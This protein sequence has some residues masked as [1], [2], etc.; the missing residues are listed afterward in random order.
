[1]KTRRTVLVLA[2]TNCGKLRE[3]RRA[4]KGLPVRIVTLAEV[5]IR[6]V[7]PERGRTFSENARGKSLYYSRRPG[8]LTLAEDSGLVVDALAGAPGI[9]SARFSAPRATAAKNNRKVLRLLKS[10][11]AGKRNARFVCSMALANNG[12]LLRTVSGVVRGTIA[13]EKKGRFGFGYD[14]IFY[15]RPWRRTF[16][17]VSPKKKNAVSHRGRALKKMRAFLA[18]FLKNVSSVSGEQIQTR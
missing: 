15:Y 8:H 1:V 18:D 14:P 17:Q 16:G 13:Y 12:K 7:Y 3:I 10:A 2:T 6:S 4:L 9:L 11:P 5:G